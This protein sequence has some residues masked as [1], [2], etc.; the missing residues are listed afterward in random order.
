MIHAI[1]DNYA[2]TSIP[3]C[4]DG[5]RAIRAGHS[6]SPRPRPPGSMR[7]KAFLPS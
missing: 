3:R 1:L 7:S 4:T 2:P 6:T 5:W